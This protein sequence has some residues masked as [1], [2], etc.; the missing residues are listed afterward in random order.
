MTNKTILGL[1]LVA[2]GGFGCAVDVEE[3]GAPSSDELASEAP[4]EHVPHIDPGYHAPSDPGVAFEQPTHAQVALPA[5]NRPE[6][7]S[8]VDDVNPG[9][10]GGSKPAPGS[11]HRAADLSELDS[12]DSD[13]V[14]AY[15]DPTVGSVEAGCFVFDQ[16]T[17][18]WVIE[19][20]PES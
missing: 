4:G 12:E 2:F 10:S 15:D 5:P 16:T 11:V 1:I 7:G 8:I 6:P 19:P 13:D 9:A 17:H 3:G 20:C 14:S 18:E